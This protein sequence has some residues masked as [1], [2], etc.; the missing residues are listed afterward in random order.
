M[1]VHALYFHHVTEDRWVPSDR[2]TF[3]PVAQSP[4]GF[5]YGVVDSGAK[6]G[7]SLEQLLA[8][9]RRKN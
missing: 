6:A 3:V 7:L 2:A 9:T 5:G 8:R 1:A 4:M